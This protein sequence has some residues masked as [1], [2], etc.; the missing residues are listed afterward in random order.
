MD[1]IKLE[2]GIINQMLPFRFETG[3]SFDNYNQDNNIWTK[4]D[5]DLVKLDFL[6]EHVKD[7]FSKNS[8]AGKDDDSASI[9]MKLKKEAL[10]VKMFNNRTY[11]LSN[12]SFENQDQSK[13]PLKF[14][15]CFDPNTFRII[16]HPSTK[17][18]I[19]LFTIEIAKPGKNNDPASLADFIKMNYLLRLFN[20]HNEPFFISQNDRPEERG[21]AA[22]LLTGI[23]SDL[24][25][26][27]DPG[28]IETT[29]W[30]PRQLINYLLNGFNERYKVEFFDNS[31][32]SPVCYVQPAE[33]IANEEI[34]SRT[35]FYLRKVCD[36]DYAP[37]I[38]SLQ[39]EKELIHPFKQIYYGT[40]L[41]GAVVLNNCSSTDPE[42]IRTFYSNSFQKSV[43][44]YILGVLQR[45]IFLQLLKEVSDLDPDDPHI[46]KEYLRRYTSISLK[47]I[48]SKVSVYHQHNDY[49]D[50]II[51]NLQI[52]ELRSELKD[53]LYE[54]NNLQRQFHEDEMEKH[55]EIEKQHDKRLNMILFALSIFGLTEL[56][57]R[58]I[59]N[60][61]LSLFEH[62]IAF[63]IPLILGFIFWKIVVIRKK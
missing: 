51:H 35:L 1:T 27:T 15:V 22:Q 56:I 34:I 29:G 33:E 40:S 24:F 13:N 37:T 31:R 42:F 32:F 49:Y 3:S 47:A 10:P 20:R 59:E 11:W 7:F 17:I 16:I 14:A 4:T 45:A 36:F 44:L 58:V 54:L 50:L 53:E 62:F 63:G 38:E 55:E 5:D 19:L 41:E 2:K 43:W 61:R 28:N 60:E 52:N 6:L 21:K 57:Y 26:K 25:D 12:K 48:F 18:A 46:V 30:R 39:L 8:I 9:I 23:N